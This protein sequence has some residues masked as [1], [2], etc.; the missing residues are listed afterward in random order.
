MLRLDFVTLSCWKYSQMRSPKNSFYKAAFGQETL[1]T[2]TSLTQENFK[3]LYSDSFISNTSKARRQRLLGK[4][5]IITR[6]TVSFD[7]ELYRANSALIQSRVYE[8]RYQS[9]FYKLFQKVFRVCLKPLVISKKSIKRD[10][11]AILSSGLFSPKWY[12]EKYDL[13]GTDA[14]L[15]KHYLL[16]GYASLL[17]P[18]KDF[19]TEL[20]LAE[21]LDV[22][23]SNINPLLHYI[24]FGKA[25]KRAIKSA[26]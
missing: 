21:N 19:S 15:A 7:G 22:M 2:T 12:A 1:T 17:N 14:E 24:L 9:K 13:S 25:E 20:Y 23:L 6:R 26:K 16:Y 3:R 18:S 11:S 10:T 4:K 5:T 8:G